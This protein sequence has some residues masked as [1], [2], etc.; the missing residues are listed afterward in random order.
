MVAWLVVAIQ[1]AL[2]ACH[3][4]HLAIEAGD[5]DDAAPVASVFAA[6]LA[7]AV[8]IEPQVGRPAHDES[9]C[10]I[11]RAVLKCRAATMVGTTPAIVRIEVPIC[12]ALVVRVIVRSPVI[13]GE[14]IARGPP[15]PSC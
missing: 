6:D 5:D 2:P 10:A 11:C 1:L 4:L 8:G 13:V 9:H 12:P 14:S 7:H 15:A 3:W